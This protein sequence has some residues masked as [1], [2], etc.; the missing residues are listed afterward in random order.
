MWHEGFGLTALHCIS[1]TSFGKR[2]VVPGF[3]SNVEYSGDHRLSP[4]RHATAGGGNVW[5]TAE[6]ISENDD[7][8]HSQTRGIQYSTYPIHCLQKYWVMDWEK[9]C[10]HH[11][12]RDGHSNMCWPASSLFVPTPTLEEFT[13]KMYLAKKKKQKWALKGSETDM[14]AYIQGVRALCLYWLV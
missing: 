6:V 12:A 13:T 11:W 1:L 7:I 3:F 14:T 2:I 8:F 9:T 5:V 10:W 4:G